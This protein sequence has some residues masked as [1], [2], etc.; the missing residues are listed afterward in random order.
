MPCVL[1]DDPHGFNKGSRVWQTPEEGRRTYQPK[2]C[3]NNNKDEDNSPKNLNDKNQQASS[4]KFWQLIY[5]SKSKVLYYFDNGKYNLTVPD[6]VPRSSRCWNTMS[7]E[8]PNLPDTLRVLLARLALMAGS[9]VSKSSFR[10]T[11]RCLIIEAFATLA[12]CLELSG[13]CTMINCASTFCTIN[14]FGY[15]RGIMSEFELMKHKFEV[16]VV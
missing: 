5:S 13:Y 12:K 10:L 4:Q 8:R 15:F 9:T 16:P 6:T 3:G 14:V 1:L 2:R 11:W 7:Y